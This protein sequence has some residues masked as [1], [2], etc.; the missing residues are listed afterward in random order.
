[1]P[2][3]AITRSRPL[4]SSRASHMPT[5][6][7]ASATPMRQSHS[8]EARRPSRSPALPVSSASVAGAAISPP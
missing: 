5:S 2:T 3:R 8:E 1:M 4:A 7:M 6:A